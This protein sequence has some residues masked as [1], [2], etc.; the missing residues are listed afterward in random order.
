MEL[1]KSYSYNLG[2]VL[3]FKMFL[4]DW[5]DFHSLKK[6]IENLI[7]RKK[8]VIEPFSFLG[9]SD[10]PASSK[11]VS[12]T[13]I[14]DKF[15]QHFEKKKP[16]KIYNHEKL[17]IG[18]V[19]GDFHDH[20]VLH[21]ITDVFKNHDKTK[22]DLFAFSYGPIRNDKWRNEVKK[23][24]LNF[25]DINKLSD[26]NVADLIKKNEI[27]II[28]DLSGLTGNSRSGIFS[29]RAAPIQINYLGYPGTTGATYMD[30]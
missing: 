29:Y 24:F 21:L 13:F 5:S 25:E 20:P 19:S 8:K 30:L 27:D 7:S 18:Y 22:F 1:N 11:I 12:E 4:S 14:N 6:E 28:I 16:I 26:K 2:K 15:S 17:K 23:Y 3:H 10:D 9:L